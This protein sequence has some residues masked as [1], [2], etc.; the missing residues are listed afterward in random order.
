MLPHVPLSMIKIA[1]NLDSMLNDLG[2]LFVCG[3]FKHADRKMVTTFYN[4]GSNAVVASD[5]PVAESSHD[6]E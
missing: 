1:G 5:K 3:F 2:M 4:R 6:Y